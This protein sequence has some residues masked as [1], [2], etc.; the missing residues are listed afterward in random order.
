MEVSRSGKEFPGVSNEGDVFGDMDMTAESY[1]GHVGPSAKVLRAT[2]TTA[3]P[4]SRLRLAR[5]S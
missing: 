3:M 2:R 4:A 5:V 1:N